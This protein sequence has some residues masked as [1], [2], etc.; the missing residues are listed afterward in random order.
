MA[1][2]NIQFGGVIPLGNVVVANGRNGLEIAD[3]AAGGTYFNTF[4]GIPAFDMRS[5]IL[6]MGSS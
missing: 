4:C 6:S 2:A 3:T 5:A 1:R